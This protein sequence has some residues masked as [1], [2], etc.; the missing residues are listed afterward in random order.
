MAIAIDLI[1][2]YLSSWGFVKCS[3]IACLARI[4]FRRVKRR[5]CSMRYLLRGSRV[6]EKEEPSVRSLFKGSKMSEI[7]T[8]SGYEYRVWL[9]VEEKRSVTPEQFLVSP[10]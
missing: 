9:L 8:R 5:V 7:R 10:R 3:R 4:K 1:H 2:S 6:S